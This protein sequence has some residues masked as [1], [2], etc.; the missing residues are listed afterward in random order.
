[1]TTQRATCWSITIN[2]P[3]EADY[4]P[5]MPG[6]WKLT[7]QMELGEKEETPHY[8]GMLKTPQVR[9]S[10]VK[11]LFPRAHIEA[12]KNPNGLATYVHKEETR[13]AEVP[14]HVSNIP[15]IFDYHATVAKKW[16]AE[17][18]KTFTDSF[19]D[20]QVI[21]LGTD[22]IALRYVDEI[23]KRDIINGTR[24]I[25]FIAVNPMWRNAWK[26]FHRAI[27][28][29]E[30]AV[31]ISPIN[32][33]GSSQFSQTPFNTDSTPSSRRSSVQLD[34]TETPFVE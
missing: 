30:Q 10:Q 17:D 21:K 19:S 20:A 1:M 32:I 28:I 33:N 7:G 29:R 11:Q 16:N 8:Q 6:G 3:T 26:K 12:A 31:L 9:F 5:T 27:I 25:E 24:G 18:Y 15:T 23:V 14:D 34:E 4:T 13:V 2:N 22:E